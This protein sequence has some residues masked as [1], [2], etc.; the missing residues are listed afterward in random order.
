[1]NKLHYYTPFIPILILVG[2]A[3]YVIKSGQDYAENHIR[4]C[5]GEYTYQCQICRE[6]LNTGYSET[7]AVF[8]LTTCSGYKECHQEEKPH[9]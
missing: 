7:C 5:T 2:I 4:V 3:C 8:E 9:D 6:W 1:M